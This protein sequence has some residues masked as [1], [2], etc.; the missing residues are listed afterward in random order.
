MAIIQIH[1]SDDF[2]SVEGVGGFPLNPVLVEGIFGIAVRVALAKIQE[3]RSR[4][5]VPAVEMP[6]GM[7]GRGIIAP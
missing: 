1:V 3:E 2:Q 4:K 6:P 5:V 7:N